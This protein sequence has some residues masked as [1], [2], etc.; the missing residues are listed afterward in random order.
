MELSYASLKAM[1]R[2]VRDTFPESLALRTHRALSWLNRAESEQED[3]DAKFIFLWIALNAAYAHEITDRAK[4]T[5]RRMFLRFLDRLIATDTEDLLHGI[6]WEHFPGPVRL[7]LANQYVSQE[8]WDFHTGRIGPQEWELRFQSSKS[9]ATRAL[10]KRDTKRVIAI[11]FD[12]LYVLR[13]QLIHGGA[14]WNSTVNRSQLRDGGRILAVVVPAII[15]L[16]L[17]SPEQEWGTPSY[18]VIRE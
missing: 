15:Y 9:A 17:N 13:N 12:R 5:E 4:F 6:V 7:L 10:G 1:H 18:P 11:V 2:E 3:A 14:T 16:L 8:F